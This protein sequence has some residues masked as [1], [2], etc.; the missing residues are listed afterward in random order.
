MITV[1]N[2]CLHIFCHVLT[3]SVIPNDKQV[4]N[5][6]R[7]HDSFQI[8]IYIY[9]DAIN[10]THLWYNTTVIDKEVV[11]AMFQIKGY[12]EQSMIRTQ[13]VDKW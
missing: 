3:W 11:R 2:P 13:H 5:N 7:L 4:R 9:I 12:A 6:D 8:C 10:K 1:N